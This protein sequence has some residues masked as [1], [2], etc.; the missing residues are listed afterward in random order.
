MALFLSTSTLSFS[1]KMHLSNGN[2]GKKSNNSAADT[3]CHST[4]ELGISLLI[5]QRKKQMLREGIGPT[6]EVPLPL[7]RA[8]LCFTAMKENGCCVKC[9]VPAY[10]GLQDRAL[11]AWPGSNPVPL[12]LAVYVTLGE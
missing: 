9:Q 1:F 7:R 12:F 5:L 11:R 4:P 6:E 10:C 3:L 2:D 8:A